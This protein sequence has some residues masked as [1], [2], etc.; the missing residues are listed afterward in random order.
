MVG[1][2]D[3]IRAHRPNVALRFGEREDDGAFGLLVRG[4]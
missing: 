1:V 2:D 3:G 4:R